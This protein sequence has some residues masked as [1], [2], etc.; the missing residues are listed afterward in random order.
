MIMISWVYLSNCFESP[1]NQSRQQVARM[2]STQSKCFSVLWINNTKIAHIYIQIRTFLSL[3]RPLEPGM[4]ILM[5][6]LVHELARTTCPYHLRHLVL[7]AAVTS[8]FPNFAYR[9][10]IETSSWGFRPQIQRI[11]NLSFRRSCCKSWAD[12]AQ[13]SLPYNRAEWTR[14][15]YTFP[16]VM[17]DTCLNIRIGRSLLN[18]PR[19]CNIW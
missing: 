11:I 10:S 6:E 16:W 2:S 12:G 13:V 18:F 9:V 3:H 17:R 15:L 14:A 4:A 7:E 1:R 19:Q 8:C 5:I